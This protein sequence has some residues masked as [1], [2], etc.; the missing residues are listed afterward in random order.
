[1]LPN[2]ID[3]VVVTVS[4]QLQALGEADVPLE[5]LLDE[6][7]MTVSV[8]DHHLLTLALGGVNFL[9]FID[10]DRHVLHRVITIVTVTGV[11]VNDATFLSLH[12]LHLLNVLVSNVFIF[13][14]HS[15]H[16]S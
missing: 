15:K 3:A 5:P 11:Y 1:M 12:L 14:S 6:L 9:L 2:L 8:N 7:Q 4:I 13:L 10:I 16:L